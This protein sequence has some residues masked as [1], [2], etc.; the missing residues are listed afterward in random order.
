M[1]L[2]RRSNDECAEILRLARW[3]K[4]P[5]CPH[6]GSSHVLVESQRLRGYLQRYHCRDCGRRSNDLTGTGFA[7][8]MSGLWVCF[9]VLEARAAGH[10]YARIA[11]ALPISLTNTWHLANRAAACPVCSRLVAAARDYDRARG[12]EEG[13]GAV[14]RRTWLDEWVIG[15]IDLDGGG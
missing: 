1:R 15:R 2:R 13:D 7:R 6:C 5:R 11:G 9:Y 8:T 10:T 4:G 3:T 14:D 12:T